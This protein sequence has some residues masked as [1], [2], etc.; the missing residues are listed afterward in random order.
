MKLPIGMEFKGLPT[1]IL[2][3][4][5]GEAK[6]TILGYENAQKLDNELTFHLNSIL[7]ENQKP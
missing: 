2:I 4:K 7:G 6:A 1:L 5:S 3:D